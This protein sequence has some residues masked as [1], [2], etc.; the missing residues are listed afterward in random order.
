MIVILVFKYYYTKKGEV[1]RNPLLSLLLY[2]HSISL[3]YNINLFFDMPWCFINLSLAKLQN[4]STPLIHTFPCL[5]LLLWSTFRCLYPQE[6]EQIIAFPFISINYTILPRLT[7]VTVSWIRV[8]ADTSFTILTETLPPL[9]RIP[10]TIVFPPAPLPLFPFCFP[11][12]YD[13]SASI[14]PLSTSSDRDNSRRMTLLRIS[15]H[16]KVVG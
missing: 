9:S 10:N 15:N 3:M 12:K 7:F 6:H 14:S 13:S 5:N 11:P 16:F 4:P 2:L 1:Y 8:S